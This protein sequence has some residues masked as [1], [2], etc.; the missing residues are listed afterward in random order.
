MT[1]VV[2]M[3]AALA[4]LLVFH[5]WASARPRRLWYLGAITPVI[6]LGVLIWM[7]VTGVFQ[8]NLLGLLF[9]GLAPMAVLL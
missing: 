7:A 4:V 8:D 5:M 6:W 1:K 3:L 9:G 2:L